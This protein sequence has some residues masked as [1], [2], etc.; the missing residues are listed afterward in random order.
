MLNKLTHGFGKHTSDD[1]DLRRIN[2]ILVY[3]PHKNGNITGR[4]EFRHLQIRKKFKIFKITKTVK[5][6]PGRCERE[7]QNQR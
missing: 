5:E 2:S 1:I 6:V 4:F 3:V 7:S